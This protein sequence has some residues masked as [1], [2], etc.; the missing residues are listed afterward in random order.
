MVCTTNDI[1]N[2]R[3]IKSM[4][5]IVLL[6]L[7]IFSFGLV[8]GQSDV[9]RFDGSNEKWFIVEDTIAETEVVKAR[10]GKNPAKQD[11]GSIKA[12]PYVKPRRSD[13]SFEKDIKYPKS[14][15]GLQDNTYRTTKHS[16]YIGTNSI[17]DCVLATNFNAELS[18]S[19]NMSLGMDSWVAWLRHKKNNDWWQN[20]GFDA[21]IHFWFGEG[22][23][24]ILHK[25]WYIGPYLGTFTY[26]L[27]MSGKGYESPDMFKTFRFGTELGHAFALGK[28]WR[29][30]IFCGVGFINTK[31]NIYHNNF[32]G[33]YY[34]SR[35]RTRNLVDFTRWG[36]TF[37]YRIK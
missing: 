18:F 9:W 21:F 27:W 37:S 35:S 13:F 34:I 32:G 24:A 1:T 30:D 31:Q 28:R 3:L 10:E 29:L 2:P 36:L 5:K 7:G 17:Y 12:S 26:D 14:G 15:A 16:I 4:K 11:F 6:L 23:N 33:G 25:G 20:Y 19:R 22:H 8:H